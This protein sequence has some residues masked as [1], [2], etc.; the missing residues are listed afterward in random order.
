MFESSKVKLG[1]EENRRL[2]GLQGGASTVVAVL[3]PVAAKTKGEGLE[4]GASCFIEV[5]SKRFTPANKVR[6][7]TAGD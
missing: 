2:V 4:A 1:A 6:G 5:E 7:R 3:D